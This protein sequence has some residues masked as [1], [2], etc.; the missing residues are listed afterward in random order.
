MA[1]QV[2]VKTQLIWRLG[3]HEKADRIVGS[4]PSHPRR[5]RVSSDDSK[6]PG[7]WY[8]FR[9]NGD[10]REQLKAYRTVR[11]M[12]FQAYC[13]TET[14]W[15]WMTKKNRDKQKKVAVEY[16]LM[17][18]YIMVRIPI[19]ELGLFFLT[20]PGAIWSVLGH[21]ACRFVCRFMRW[22]G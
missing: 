11:R 18:G 3:D 19:N 2:P 20:K 17:V 6:N 8:V 22:S 14:K 12:G 15:R 13:P 16:P 5:E 1:K 4:F 21:Q 10:G 9:C 7:G